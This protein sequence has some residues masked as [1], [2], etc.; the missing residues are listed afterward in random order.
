MCVCVLPWTVMTRAPKRPRTALGRPPTRHLNECQRQMNTPPP[1][2]PPYPLFPFAGHFRAGRRGAVARVLGELRPWPICRDSDQ[3]KTHGQA[4]LPLRP[5]LP[6][7]ESAAGPRILRTYVRE[8]VGGGGSSAWLTWLTSDV[9]PRES[10]WKALSA[11][12]LPANSWSVALTCPYSGATERP[13][14][15]VET[16]ETGPLPM[17]TRACICQRPSPPSQRV[18]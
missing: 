17:P 6:P 10:D 8:G 1:A 5:H 18:Y 12:P 3:R 14:A 11:W 4:R 13:T 15:R 9:S 2:D 16:V 7:R